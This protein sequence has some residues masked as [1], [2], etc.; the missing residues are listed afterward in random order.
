VRAAPTSTSRSTYFPQTGRVDASV[1]RLEALQPGER[2]DGPALIESSTTTIVIDP[3]ASCE[4]T[5]T[6]SVVIYP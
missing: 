6:G 5:A 2:M 3:D 1:H 4:A